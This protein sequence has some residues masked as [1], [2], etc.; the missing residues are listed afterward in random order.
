LPRQHVYA[1]MESILAFGEV[2][3]KSSPPFILAQTER[4]DESRFMTKLL[5]F[6]EQ[7]SSDCR[8]VDKSG[9]VLPTPELAWAATSTGR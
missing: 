3:P 4:L 6:V 7:K 2:E 1:P 5:N 8:N 9:T